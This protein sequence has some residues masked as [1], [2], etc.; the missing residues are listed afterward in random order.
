M[1]KTS[2]FALRTFPEF[3]EAAQ[4]LAARRVSTSTMRLLMAV[5]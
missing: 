1:S 2:N 5:S 4:A 3:K